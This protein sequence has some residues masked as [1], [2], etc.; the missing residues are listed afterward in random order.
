[1]L[2]SIERIVLV[3][4]KSSWSPD[5]SVHSPTWRLPAV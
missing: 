2:N 3:I 1:M 5:R 4:G